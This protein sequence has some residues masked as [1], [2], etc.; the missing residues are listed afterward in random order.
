MTEAAST[1]ASAWDTDNSLEFTASLHGSPRHEVADEEHAPGTVISSYRINRLLGAGGSALVYEAEQRSP[2]RLVALKVMRESHRVDEVHARLFRHEADTLARLRHPNIASIYESGHTE[3]GRDFFAMELVDGS[4]LDRWFQRLVAPGAE[5]SLRFRLRLFQAIC[6]PVHYAHQRG[7]I[8]RDLKPKNI[9]VAGDSSSV[10]PAKM[11]RVPV[12]KI[13]DFG[14]ARIAETDSKE[15]GGDR[16]R[17][18]I[19]GTLPY[20]S[21]EQA[22]GDAEAVD[23]RTDVYAL[24]VILYELLT[25][26]RPYELDTSSLS[27]SVRTICESLPGSLKL[28]PRASKTECRELQSIVFKALAK[29]P[30]DRYHSVAALREDVDRFLHSIPVTAHSSSRGY[31]AR[32]FVGRHRTGVAA[33]FLVTLALLAGIVGT[34]VGL[35]RARHAEDAARQEAASSARVAGFL[36]EL[37]A[38]M[39]AQ[40]LGQVLVSELEGRVAEAARHQGSLPAA[41]ELAVS[42]LRAAIREVSATDTGRRLLDEAIL[43]KAA[44][45]IQEQFADE[46]L[47]A[48]RL[49][50][51]LAETYERLGMYGSAAEHAERALRIRRRSLAPSAQEILQTEALL[52]KLQYR[53]GRY[54][55]AAVRLAETYRLQ[56][57]TLG[58]KHPETLAAAL[59][60]AWVMIELGQTEAAEEL[61]RETIAS[62]QQVLGVAHRQTIDSMNSLAVVFTDQKRFAEAEELHSRILEMRSSILGPDDPDT[63]KSMTN[64]AVVAYYQNRL[65]VAA[66]LFSEVLEIQRQRLGPTHPTTLGSANNL[67][68]IY[69][70]QGRLQAA[71][72]LH[73]WAL[74]EKRQ[75]LGSEH[76][77]TLSSLYNLAIVHTAQGRLEEAEKDHKAVMQVRLRRL[78]AA[79]PQT[80]ASQCA[81]AG[82]AARRGDLPRALALLEA[83]IQAGYSDADSLMSDPDF[84]SLRSDPDFLGLVTRAGR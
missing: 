67:A 50:Q 66:S 51:T 32:K 22:R 12:V 78:G 6:R 57:E 43:S 45:A 84:E 23:V 77:E 58:P 21:P 25:G 47:V 3:D 71:E 31:R 26:S 2:R 72:E 13:L 10:S 74:E 55:A 59:S 1:A 20:M 80:L 24:G 40:R 64:L 5:P 75:V 9:I 76:P 8:H 49:E 54:D 60:R 82:V 39:D 28:Q 17:G 35:V 70:Q 41:G 46:P 11:S 79:H 63:L 29:D 48:G 83:A 14:L 81:L 4:T 73:R 36:A 65:D 19:R 34:S 44:A 62:Q 69:Q 61:L 37:L 30:Q 52:G 33:V 68:V 56:T 27:R 42:T 18:S 16:D 7:V 53:Q 38:S 15:D